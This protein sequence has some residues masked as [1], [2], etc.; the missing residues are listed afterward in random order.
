MSRKKISLEYGIGK[1]NVNIFKQ[2]DKLIK[3]AITFDCSLMN[4][5][6]TIKIRTYK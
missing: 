5:R 3:F 1:S 2:N 6:K 4:K